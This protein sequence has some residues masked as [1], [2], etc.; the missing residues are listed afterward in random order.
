MAAPAK[1][2]ASISVDQ[3]GPYHVGDVIT[4]TVEPGKLKGYEFPVVNI[5]CGYRSETG[6]E[7][8]KNYVYYRRWDTNEPD[9]LDEYG[10]QPIT[11]TSAWTVAPCTVEL[12]AYGGLKGPD[13]GDHLIAAT[14]AFSVLP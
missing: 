10:P 14:A 1:A 11:I 5:W 4:L 8:V 7:D 3:P 6:F 2:A 13:G 9:P 12:W